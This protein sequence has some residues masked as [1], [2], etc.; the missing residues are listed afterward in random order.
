MATGFCLRKFAAN[1]LMLGAPLTESITAGR[2]TFIQINKGNYNGYV[3]FEGVTTPL[4]VE[5]SENSKT[6]FQQYDEYGP[7]SRQFSTTNSNRCTAM[8]F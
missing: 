4:L 7:T 3:S 1:E 6:L 2:L 8:T 5:K